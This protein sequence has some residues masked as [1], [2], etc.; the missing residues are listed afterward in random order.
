MRASDYAFWI[1]GVAIAIVGVVV[2]RRAGDGDVLQAI[3]GIVVATLG[4]MVIATGVSR[5]RKRRM[6]G[7]QTS[8]DPTIPD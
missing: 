6:S 1:I 8:G 2:K 4:L 5:V 3:A 7:A